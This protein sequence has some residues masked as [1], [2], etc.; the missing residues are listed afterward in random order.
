[1]LDRYFI[2]VL[3]GNPRVQQLGPSRGH[4]PL[5]AGLYGLQ[6]HQQPRLQGDR[7]RHG[8]EQGAAL[9]GGAVPHGVQ[10]EDRVAR[11]DKFRN[12]RDV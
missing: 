5:H 9:A 1:M 10:G 11:S 12:V 4:R 8:Q 2:F 3:V 6:A 7:V